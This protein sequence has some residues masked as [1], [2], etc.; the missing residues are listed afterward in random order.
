MKSENPQPYQNIQDQKQSK[1]QQNSHAKAST[2]KSRAKDHLSEVDWLQPLS[3]TDAI[4]QQRF[5]SS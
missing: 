1:Q 5:S 3:T 2:E 4:D